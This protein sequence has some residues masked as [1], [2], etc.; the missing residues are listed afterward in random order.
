MKKVLIIDTNKSTFIVFQKLLPEF[1][2]D[3]TSCSLSSF[4]EYEAIIVSQELFWL[5]Q[6]VK[7]VIIYVTCHE[8]AN[9]PKSN[10]VVVFA[11]PLNLIKLKKKL[12]ILARMI[13]L[14]EHLLEKYNAKY[15]DYC[16]NRS[17]IPGLDDTLKKVRTTLQNLQLSNTMRDQITLVLEELLHESTILEVNLIINRWNLMVK[18]VHKKP[19]KSSLFF[20]RSYVDELRSYVRDNITTELTWHTSAQP[21]SI[22]I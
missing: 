13:P 5:V 8:E 3:F 20:M 9:I 14:A 10:N 6:E 15:D 11:A 1:D 19:L 12:L 7:E 22:K 4:G 17:W 2:L 18:I 21:L 16:E